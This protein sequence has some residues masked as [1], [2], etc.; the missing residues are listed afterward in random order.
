MN[1]TAS[2]FQFRHTETRGAA[3]RATTMLPPA[4]P[5][6]SQ[7][8]SQSQN[9]GRPKGV[10]T[11]PN[12][13][14]ASQTTPIKRI[15]SILPN[16]VPAHLRVAPSSDRGWASSP[17]AKDVSAALRTGVPIPST[18]TGSSTKNNLNSSLRMPLSDL[19]PSRPLPDEME[20]DEPQLMTHPRGSESPIKARYTDR[21]LSPLSRPSMKQTAV[22]INHNLERLGPDVNPP[23]ATQPA[24]PPASGSS[25]SHSSTTI[26]SSSDSV[27]G[28]SSRPSTAAVQIINSLGSI[29]ELNGLSTEQLEKIVAEVIREP[30]FMTLVCS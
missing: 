28:R 22:Q 15:Q 30:G 7:A 16:S 13:P 27:T 1:A 14:F 20:V 3:A 19:Q 21:P 9:V 24:P 10:P 29:E 12:P 2:I 5:P 4:A 18:S 23:P 25:A 6:Q 11:L 17:L 8:E 26:I